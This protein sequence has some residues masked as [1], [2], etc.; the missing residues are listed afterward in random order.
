[1]LLGLKKLNPAYSLFADS[2]CLRHTK[3]GNN[4]IEA[5]IL[6][7]KFPNCWVHQGALSKMQTEF[8]LRNRHKHNFV[9]IKT[10]FW[11]VVS[12]CLPLQLPWPNG[13]SSFSISTKVRTIPLLHKL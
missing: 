6:N 7:S 5:L 1:M 8:A 9:P 4:I 2:M 11:V 12:L 3:W 13:N 10:Y